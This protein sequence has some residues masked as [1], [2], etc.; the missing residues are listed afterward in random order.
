MTDVVEG[1]DKTYSLPQLQQWVFGQ[2]KLWGP[3]KKIGN[4]G[5]KTGATFDWNNPGNP[6]PTTQAT[7]EETSTGT[8][9][10][11]KTKL[12]DGWVFISSALKRVV[13]YR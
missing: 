12:A 4:D 3:I 7:I 10:A 2:E 8:V 11:G 5:A 6:K 1:A 13:V 9:P